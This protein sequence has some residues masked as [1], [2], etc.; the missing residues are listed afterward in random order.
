[1]F[2]DQGRN[3]PCLCNARKEKQFSTF[4]SVLAAQTSPTSIMTTPVMASHAR[5]QREEGRRITPGQLPTG[6][7][8]LIRQFLLDLQPPQLT[9]LLSL[10]LQS[11]L[12]T[13]RLFVQAILPAPSPHFRL[14]PARIPPQRS[15]QNR[16]REGKYGNRQTWTALW[17][18]RGRLFLSHQLT[19]VTPAISSLQES[20][21]R[22]P[23]A[24]TPSVNLLI[25]LS[26]GSPPTPTCPRPGRYRR[27]P[28]PCPPS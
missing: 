27:T 19:S 4:K 2:G 15:S 17:R 14:S 11:G 28:R 22:G 23:G 13:A 18:D 24:R 21:E 6:R 16:G 20:R 1:M 5:N 25:Q 3:P 10:P 7:Q 26:L 9:F 12:I 8:R